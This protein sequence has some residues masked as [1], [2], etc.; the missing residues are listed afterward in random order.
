MEVVCGRRW[1]LGKD[2]RQRVSTALQRSARLQKG[3][4]SL[5][6]A[7]IQTWPTEHRCPLSCVR[8]VKVGVAERHQPR[9]RV[10]SLIVMHR[11]KAGR[12]P[13][14]LIAVVTAEHE[15]AT[16]RKTHE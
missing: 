14:R 6:R 3:D 9:H 5:C 4:V 16:I 2:T 7:R 1:R 13:E 11:R 10:R 12:L 15:H 8:A